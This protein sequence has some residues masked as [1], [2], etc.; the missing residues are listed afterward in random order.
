MHLVD[1]DGLEYAKWDEYLL[2]VISGVKKG[3]DQK[4]PPESQT[5]NNQV[6]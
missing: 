5:N 2:G 6:G 4:M 1:L 3:F